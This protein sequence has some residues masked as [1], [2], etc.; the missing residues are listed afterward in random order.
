MSAKRRTI[1]GIFVVLAIFVAL[2]YSQLSAP[3]EGG[4]R[5]LTNTASKAVYRTTSVFDFVPNIF[6]SKQK[7]QSAYDELLAK[8]QDN[9]V[10][11]VELESLRN[12]NTE[13]REQLSFESA[14][15]FLRLGADTIG[16]NIDPSGSTILVNRGSVDGVVVGS[17]AIAGSGIL[18]G[19]VVEV[20][21]DSSLVQLINDR[22]SR[23]AATI[24][25]QEKSIGVVEGGFGISITMRFIPQNELIRPGDT[26]ITSGL[27]SGVP[28]DLLIGT[29]EVVEKKPQEPFQ[30][31]VLR[32]LYNLKHIGPVTLL[33]SR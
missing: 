20:Y 21:A 29:V 6:T 11:R 14:D 16:K 8:H 13:L 30:E 3:I 5:G 17:P 31:A 23:I 1:L 10:D 27:Q 22:Q 25:N 18:V 33:V 12:E 7:I 32:P 19:T 15:A 4:L 26:V 9:L 2:H 24:I 28:R